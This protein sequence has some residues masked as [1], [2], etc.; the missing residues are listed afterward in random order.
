M[1]SKVNNHSQS[2][3]KSFIKDLPKPEKEKVLMIERWRGR[4]KEEGREDSVDHIPGMLS[5]RPLQ[6]PR[7]QTGKTHRTVQQKRA[8]M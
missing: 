2:A 4:K 3:S 1:G 8:L 5:Q 6:P 7:C